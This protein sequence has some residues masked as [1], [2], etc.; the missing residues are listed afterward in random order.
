EMVHKHAQ[1]IDGFLNE[2]LKNIQF[3]SGDSPFERLLDESVLGEKL[4]RLQQKYDG[5]FEDLG[6]IDEEGI[7]ISYA[8]PF[9]LKK[10]RYG[11]A[12]WFKAALENPYYISDVFL[13]LRSRPHFNVSVRL[14]H[15]DRYFLLRATINFEA[16]NTVAE[17][18]RI[19]ETGF[20][21]I[22]NKEGAFQ[23][24]PHYDMP[25]IKK[26]YKDFIDAGKRT[27]HGIYVGEHTAGAGGDRFIYFAAPLKHEDWLLVYQQEKAEAL[28]DL[29]R[30]QLAAG[31]IILIGALLMVLMNLMLYYKVVNRIAK[32]DREKE[33][34]N[35]RVIET[36]KLASAGR[37]AAVGR[38]AVGIAHEI[39]N[40]VAIM[41]EEAGWIRDLLEDEE[42]KQGE[43]LEEIQR[44]LIQI[45]AQGRRC[46]EITHNL[47]SFARKT[48]AK[49]RR[50]MINEIIEEVVK[51][52][53]RSSYTGISILSHLDKRV[54]P[55]HGSQGDVQQVFLNLINNARYVL[56]ENGGKIHITS[57]LE[58][59][60]VLVVV[61]DDGPGIPETDLDR[62]FDPFYTTKPAGK[63]YGLGLSICFGIIDKMG[64]EIDVRDAMDGGAR[65]EIRFP[66]GKTVDAPRA[67]SPSTS[68]S[69]DSGE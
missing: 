13:G 53:T 37:L 41:V 52:S 39:N 47:L 56:E 12:K 61:E 14:V 31:L 65:F 22:L 59:R 42:F 57:L 7:Q 50:V 67:E 44:A 30:I 64:G 17:N 4:V 66:L 16:F 9:K 8:G 38:L 40:P 35:Q 1:N 6:I 29:R 32:A 33:M 23:T 28:A 55:I 54:P 15:Q 58:E 69:T 45:G 5:V 36:G 24:K 34:M 43:N 10:A 19:G 51:I 46:G 27:N 11:E 2:R 18:L 63:G 21:F 25:L 20:A 26:S 62:I 68:T 60:H 49:K 48:H 3:L